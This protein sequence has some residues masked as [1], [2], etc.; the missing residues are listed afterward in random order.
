MTRAAL[1]PAGSDPYLLAYWLRHYR[2]W[3]D[4]VDELLIGACGL[5]NEEAL[6]LVRLARG[7]PHVRF[8]WSPDRTDH[9]AVIG[10]LVGMTDAT[11]VLLCEDDAYIRQPGV[12]DAMFRRIESGETDAIGSPR[13]NAS[14]VLIERAK[15]L[16]GEVPTVSTGEGGWSCYPCTFFARRA[17]LLATDRHF[18]AH[19]WTSGEWIPGLEMASPGDTA[20]DT[21]ACTTW[22]LRRAGLRI[23]LEPGYRTDKAKMGGW[24][25]PWFHVGSLSTGWRGTFGIPESDYATALASLDDRYEQA[26]R[27]SWWQRAWEAAAPGI[28]GHHAEYGRALTRWMADAGVSAG[29]V[30]EWRRAFDHLVAW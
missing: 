30:A 18:G 11:H 1:L 10:R 22:Q 14:G 15:D 29:D 27:A 21:F 24:S 25:P 8:G 2:A 5:S 3:A 16:W 4:E 23:A 12:V 28:P 26:K 9:G 19:G 20:A 17:D 6:Y 7:L 13:G